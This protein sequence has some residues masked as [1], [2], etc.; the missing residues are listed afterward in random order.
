MAKNYSD[1]VIALAG[2]C[3]AATI[4]HNLAHTGEYD[5]K[6]FNILIKSLDSFSPDS[7]LGVYGNDLD[8]LKLG[9]TTI[10]DMLSGQT[11]KINPEIT[12]YVVSMSA[13][14][15]RLMNNKSAQ[16]QLR[17]RLYQY[18][19]QSVFFKDE[20]EQQYNN[21]AGI[22][23]DVIS[24]LGQRIQVTG[25]EPILK[26][27]NVQAKVRAILLGGIRASVLWKQVGGTR[28]QVIFFRKK[29]VQTANELLSYTQK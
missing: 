23:V 24:P 22:Y 9:L 16:E 8:N 21:L 7:T 20:P 29:I 3:Q 2:L 5:E 18:Q 27:S 1:I 26:N 14:E 28:W 10:S 4:V 13:I 17:Q 12:R 25:S 11:Q 6:S 19:Q 15:T